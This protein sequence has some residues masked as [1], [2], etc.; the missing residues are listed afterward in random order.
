MEGFNYKFIDVMSI[1]ELEEINNYLV[2]QLYNPYFKYYFSGTYFI[3]FETKK[4]TGWNYK[5]FKII[6]EK[7]K[8]LGHISLNIDRDG[9]AHKLSIFVKPEYSN[10]GYG[11]KALTEFIHFCTYL[12]L[13]RLELYTENPNLKLF[14][15]KCGF[16][17]VGKFSNRTVLVDGKSYDTYLFEINLTK[18]E[19]KNGK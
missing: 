8:I 18:E 6:S 10:L 13:T 9:N 3:G 17:Y 7:S 12:G 2:S 5:H 19:D 1:S 15:E 4:N 16:N 11:K 14:Y